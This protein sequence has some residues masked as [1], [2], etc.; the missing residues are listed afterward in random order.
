MLMFGK[1]KDKSSN[2]I[3][4][5]F[6]KKKKKKKEAIEIWDADVDNVEKYYTKKF[7]KYCVNSEFI[8]MIKIKKNIKKKNNKKKKKLI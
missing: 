7:H 4:L 8:L 6:K 5:W 3:I 1:T 2:K